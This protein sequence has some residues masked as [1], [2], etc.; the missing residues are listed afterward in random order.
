MRATEI[1]KH[2]HLD[3][4]FV[5]TA[6]R[7]MAQRIETGSPLDAGSADKAV[8]I[9]RNFVDRCHHVKEERHLFRELAARAKS[10]EGGPIAV[11]VREHGDGRNHIL[12]MSGALPAASSNDTD[13]ARTFAEHAAAYAALMSQHITKEQ[14]TVFAMADQVLS[15]DDDKRLVEAFE[16]IEQ[17]ALGEGG[18]ERYERWAHEL[19]E[20]KRRGSAST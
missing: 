19:V 18:H 15:A 14:Q 16:A 2:D 6:L 9:L 10:S 5:L 1:L 17:G 4:A 11:M 13:A 7:R 20:H 12:M 3:I 8:D